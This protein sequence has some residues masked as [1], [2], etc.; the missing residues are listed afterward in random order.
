[1]SAGHGEGGGGGGS[2]RDES[3]DGGSSDDDM[4]YDEADEELE[5]L[6][7]SSLD[8]SGDAAAAAAAV[9]GAPAYGCA[10]YR[11][12]CRLRAPCCG[13]VYQCRLCHDD[14]RARARE[15]RTVV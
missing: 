10:H 3:G 13:G 11:R 2:D 15:R 4:A 8:V 5:G 7:D 6:G 9:V 12:R 14:V 1:M